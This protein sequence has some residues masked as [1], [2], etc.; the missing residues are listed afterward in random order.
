MKG[1]RRWDG[2]DQVQ[3][4]CEKVQ[5]KKKSDVSRR[6]CPWGRFCR[7]RR[8]RTWSHGLRAFVASYAGCGIVQVCVL[9]ISSTS[10]H[11]QG[12][13]VCF[14]GGAE[15][16]S[17]ALVC[18]LLCVG[19]YW[20]RYSYRTKGVSTL[21]YLYVLRSSRRSAR[22]GMAMQMQMVGPGSFAFL[23]TCPGGVRAL[24]SGKDRRRRPNGA[25]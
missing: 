3:E 9:G 16:L 12:W 20:L 25:L 17:V 8:Y 11:A 19:R 4:P 15:T 14:V 13:F 7:S 18:L 22:A 21:R 5:E 2:W 6:S 1:I 24:L 23:W 10:K